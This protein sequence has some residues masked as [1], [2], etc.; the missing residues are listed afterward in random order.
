MRLACISGCAASTD[1][2]CDPSLT[3][4][5]KQSAMLGQDRNVAF[6]EN[7]KKEIKCCKNAELRLLSL[8]GG[9]LTCQSSIFVK[10]KKMWAVFELIHSST[11]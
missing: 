1:T 2:L 9:T 10:K 7:P 4:Q 5:S 3:F 11:I 6:G 8:S